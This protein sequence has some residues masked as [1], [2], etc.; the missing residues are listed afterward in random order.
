MIFYDALIDEFSRRNIVLRRR[1]V[2]IRRSPRAGIDLEPPK[3]GV[4]T[5]KYLFDSVIY[6][7]LTAGVFGWLWPKWL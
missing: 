2:R 5:F 7:M 4:V 6:A 3:L 1:F